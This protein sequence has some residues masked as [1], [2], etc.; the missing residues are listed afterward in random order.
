MSVAIDPVCSMK[1]DTEKAP[2]HSDY[3]HKT[4]YFCC[5]GCKKKFDSNPAQY[6][7]PKP[8]NLV[9]LSP[10]FATSAPAS[11][12]SAAVAPLNDVEYTCPMHPEVRQLGPGSCPICGMALEPVEVT[13]ED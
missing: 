9:Q 12:A 2:A 8:I 11:A 13:V 7:A 1:V 4:Y 5:G 3:Q 6:L 10:A